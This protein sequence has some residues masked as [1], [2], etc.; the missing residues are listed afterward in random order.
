LLIAL[1]LAVIDRLPDIGRQSRFVPTPRAFDAPLKESASEYCHNVWYGKTRMM[2]LPMDVCVIA[3][4]YT[5]VHGLPDCEKKLKTCL[6]ISTEYTNV[7]DRRTGGQMNTAR[8]HRP[9]LYSIAQ[10][11]AASNR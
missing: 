1:A 4:Y 8:R 7:T 2:W 9:R 11:K 5:D 3:S 10:R 6:L